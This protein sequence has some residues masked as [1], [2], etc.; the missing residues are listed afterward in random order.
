[1][2]NMIAH[3]VDVKRAFLHREFED[4]EK[5]HMKIPQG[6]ETHLPAES[7]ILLLKCLYE[8]KQAAK[9]F[10]DNCYEPRKCWDYHKA[11]Q[12]PV[13]TSNGFS[14]IN[15]NA[16]GGQESDVLDL[17]KELMKQFKCEDCGPMNE[18]VGCRIETHKSGG[19]KF[20]QK[21]LLQ[22]Y[23]DEFNIK[24][25]EEIQYPGSTW[26]CSQETNRWRCASYAR[27]TDVLF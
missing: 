13:S 12:I 17:K 6:F 27:E 26:N 16:I 19:F 1:M 23:R 7:V 14:W 15:D 18:Y 11:M 22:S 21:V 25:S 4:E 9:A 10:G 5:I 8:L 20:L 2:A 24:K 3:V